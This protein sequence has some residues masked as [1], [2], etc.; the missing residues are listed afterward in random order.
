ME[1][2]VYILR[3][4]AGRHYIGSTR[5]LERRLR[6]HLS[7]SC[8]TTRR[9][10]GDITCVIKGKYTSLGEARAMERRLKR[11]KNPKAAIAFIEA[12]SSPD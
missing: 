2:W 12:K 8:H 11:M 5:N 7:N 9:L 1:A 4:S 3:G 10:G 6:E